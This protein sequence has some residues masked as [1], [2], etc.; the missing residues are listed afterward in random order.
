MTMSVEMFPVIDKAVS[1]KLWQCHRLNGNINFTE[2]ML[3]IKV[4]R[5]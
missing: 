5:F 1:N 4:H 2:G 3:N